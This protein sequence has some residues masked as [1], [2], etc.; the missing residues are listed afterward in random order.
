LSAIVIKPLKR[1]ETIMG[2][3]SAG[4]TDLE[5]PGT[6]RNDEIGNMARSAE[7]FRIGIV[8]SN[9]LRERQD[10]L[11]EEQNLE[12]Q[13]M[14]FELDQSV[15]IVV[16]EAKIGHFDQRVTK[17]FDEDAFNNIGKGVNDI[18]HNISDFLDDLH[19]SV[20]ALA[21]GDLT[22]R[23]SSK[24]TGKFGEMSEL[25]NSSL[26]N[27]AQ[28]IDQLSVTGSS[29]TEKIAVSAKSARELS[30]QTEQQAASLEETA[31]A[32]EEMRASVASNDAQADNISSN[33]SEAQKRAQ[34]GREV[35]PGAVAAMADIE[36]S[37]NKVTEIIAVIDGIAFQ[38]NLLALNAAVE[39]ARAGDAGKG[40][41]VVASEV[42]TLAQRSSEA[43]NDIKNLI[44][45]SQQKVSDGSKLVHAT[46]DALGT[47]IESIETIAG[48]I[49][50]ISAATKEQSQSVS[51]I[52]AVIVD[53]D[54]NTQRN[55]TFADSSASTAQSLA[56]KAEELQKLVDVF[57]SQSDADIPKSEAA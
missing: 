15:G 14:L 39:A 37:S 35:V 49:E 43:A 30:Q 24:H 31:A 4:Q 52:T 17:T 22:H 33:T 57:K 3:L 27:L 16:S 51:E 47:I 9:M 21:N 19:Q 7:K 32:M 56:G 12:R 45:A 23:M 36:N 29:M 26:S 6:D 28:L 41:A 55:A 34:T 38:T 54:Q 18:C 48:Q 44:E 42:R 8:E 11:E 1:I 2:T 50:A 53:L 20:G 13:T 5:I 25:V 40:F 10:K 46:G